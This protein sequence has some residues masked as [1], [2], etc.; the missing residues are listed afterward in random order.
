MN[1]NERVLISGYWLFWAAVCVLATQQAIFLFQ[2]YGNWEWAFA[3]G[4]CV[5]GGKFVLNFFE[6]ESQASERLATDSLIRKL[7]LRAGPA[8]SSVH[9]LRDSSADPAF[10]VIIEQ[11]VGIERYNKGLTGQYTR[12]VLSR[13]VP[14]EI[15]VQLP[16]WPALREIDRALVSV[17]RRVW[18]LDQKNLLYDIRLLWVRTL[19]RRR[20]EFFGSFTMAGWL[21]HR[22]SAT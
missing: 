1:W 21:R 9:M 3:A 6:R 20:V 19:D 14:E 16:K 12:Q 7:L 10:A 4:I 22:D 15:A 2:G 13:A 5:A 8:E 17:S 18:N 11:T